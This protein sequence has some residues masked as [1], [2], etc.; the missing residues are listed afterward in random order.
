MDVDLDLR[1]LSAVLQRYGVLARAWPRDEGSRSVTHYLVVEEPLQRGGISITVK[2]TFQQERPVVMN[3]GEWLWCHD[4]RRRR[5]LLNL[6]NGA[7]HRNCAQPVAITD[8]QSTLVAGGKFGQVEA[9]NR[10]VTAPDIK[11]RQRQRR[12]T[13]AWRL[14]SRD[15]VCTGRGYMT[16]D[17][18][19][20]LS[21]EITL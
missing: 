17:P 18:H 20:Y 12:M 10:G 6:Q 8:G 15:E 4:R 11:K 5:S 19:G 7:G 16:V 1:T 14:P 9:H 3:P 13:R 2:P 21:D